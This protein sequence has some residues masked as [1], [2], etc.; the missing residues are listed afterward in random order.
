MSHDSRGA[1]GFALEALGITVTFGSSTVLTDVDLA[2]APGTIHGLVGPNGSGKTTL[3][4]VLSGF[5]PR[6]SG[7]VRATGRVVPPGRP[8]VAAR[9]GIGR[10]FQSVRLFPRLSVRENVEIGALARGRSTRDA[11]KGADPLLARFGLVDVAEHPAAS[12]PY[13]V[14]RMVSIARALAGDPLVLL[15]DEPCAGLDEAETDRLRDVLKDVNAEFGCAMVVVEHDMRFI[16]GLC[17][18][19]L[20]LAAGRMLAAGTPQQALADQRVIDAY[21]GA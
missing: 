10:T 5:V 4:N 21:L 19:I 1:P 3:L 15:L 8:S 6:A 20:V 2:I 9:R 7:T 17:S 16:A 13:G 18:S 12:V 14:E 11:R